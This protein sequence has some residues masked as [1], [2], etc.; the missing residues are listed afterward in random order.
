MD[1]GGNGDKPGDYDDDNYHCFDNDDHTQ[2]GCDNHDWKAFSVNFFLS[3]FLQAV[4]GVGFFSV[5][6][7]VFKIGPEAVVFGQKNAI[8]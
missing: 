5:K 3:I 1:H 6:K 2:W 7:N 8:V 4:T